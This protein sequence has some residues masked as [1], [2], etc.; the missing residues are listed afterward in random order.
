MTHHYSLS[1]TSC[2]K[3]FRGTLQ[4]RDNAVA[5]VQEAMARQGLEVETSTPQEL[6]ARIKSE[7]A[8]WAGVIKDAGIKAE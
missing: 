8:V 7:T 2:T 1:P 5:D 3:R 6:A 4:N